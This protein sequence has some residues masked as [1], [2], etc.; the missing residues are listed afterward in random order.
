MFWSM[1]L[2]NSS[3]DSQEQQLNMACQNAIFRFSGFPVSA[4]SCTISTEERGGNS[5]FAFPPLA[6]A[7]IW[8]ILMKLVSSPVSGG[9]ASGSLCATCLR[10]SC[11]GVQCPSFQAHE[12]Q[13]CLSFFPTSWIPLISDP[14]RYYRLTS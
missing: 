8:T 2:C 5:S 11:W 10:R 9:T 4:L 13:H 7:C 3:K 14:K 1:S 6:A 12:S